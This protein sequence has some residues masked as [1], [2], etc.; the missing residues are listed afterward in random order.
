MN[1]IRKH[2]LAEMD[3][4]RE[5]LLREGMK[6]PF[7]GGALSRHVADGDLRLR[8]LLYDPS[9]ASLR[10]WN[11]LL[12]EEDR[13]FAARDAG[14][15]IVGAMKDL[16]TVP[17]MAYSLPDVTAFYPDGAWWIPCI[18]Q[19]SDGL[20]AV[21][22]AMGI[23]ASFC[24]V[25][26]MLGAF[27][28]EGHFPEPDL[29]IC[30][31]GAACSDFSAIAQRLNG[32]GRPIY[33]WE[34]PH[35]R[36]P[37]NGEETRPLP[38]GKEAPADQVRF[39]AG[40]L[41]GVRRQLEMVSGHPL[42]EAALQAGI[43]SANR[44]RSLLNRLREA[45]FTAPACPL[46]ALEM[47]IAEMLIIHYCSDL[48]ETL[49]VFE[50]LLA[51][52]ERRV[53]SST[54]VLDPDA[55][56]IFWVNPAADILAMNLLEDCGGR[57]CGSDYL[58][59]HALDPIPEDLPPMD[60]LARSALADPMAGSARDRAERICTDVHRFGCEAVLVARISGASHCAHEGEIIA[61]RVRARCGIPVLEIEI[62]PVIDPLRAALET[63]IAA[64]VETVKARRGRP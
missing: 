41:E 16:G 50:G 5:T 64:L 24:P 51:E 25:R 42:D 40:E 21:A 28:T 37:V 7:Y 45:V 14:R 1:R 56:R 15:R 63:R 47:L 26:A 62:P 13:L 60:A 58:F 9:E 61:E 20:F 22:D 18:M 31:T 3:T 11:F 17:V 55:A 32:L 27:T 38:G 53:A 46:P 34:I 35:R 23:D 59:T 43:R 48:D 10:L 39:V 30:S 8:R 52:V 36:A 12:T 33:W 6:E 19:L 44:A 29:L 54:A 49:A 57:V 2:T 4:L